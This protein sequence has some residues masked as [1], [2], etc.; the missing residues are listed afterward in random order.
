MISDKQINSIVDRV[1]KQLTLPTTIVKPTVEEVDAVGCFSEIAAAIAAAEEARRE[2]SAITVAQ[3]KKIIASIREKCLENV[4]NFA[5]LAVE[6]TGLG[7]VADKVR[8]NEVAINKTPG[9]EDLEPTAF[10]GDNGLTLVEHAPYGVIGAITPS[11]NPSETIINNTI[12]MLAGGNTV[13]F[14]PHPG[15]RKTSIFTI[16]LLNE[17]ILAAGGPPNLVTTIVEPT[18]EI[19]STRLAACHLRESL[20]TGGFQV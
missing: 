13:V 17:A 15:A 2:Y 1:V 5:H 8:K 6:E 12:S 14:N 9:I 4:R 7:R 19:Y 18:I 10:T 20:K 11:T 3:R 16:N